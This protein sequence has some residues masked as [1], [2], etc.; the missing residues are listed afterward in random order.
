[1]KNPKPYVKVTLWYLA[2][3]IVWIFVS[4]KAVD[5]IANDT[6]LLTFA[7]TIK[8]WLYVIG[9]ALLI[10][11]L[12]KKAFDTEADKEREKFKVFKTTVQG[13]HHILLNYLNQMQLV[14][15]EAERCPE[16]DRSTIKLS[17]AITEQASAELLKLNEIETVTS[18]HIHSVL[19][20]ETRRS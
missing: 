1:M 4:D 20:P 16:F 7:Q 12:T 10:F 18:D 11:C 13:V 15:M 8:G 9:S 19:Y 2:F 5:A 6:H 17:R 14:T 3:G